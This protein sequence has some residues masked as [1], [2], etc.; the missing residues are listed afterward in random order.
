MQLDTVDLL[1]NCPW[2][3]I[4][5]TKYQLKMILT[6][7]ISEFDCP[8]FGIVDRIFVCN[9]NIILFQCFKLN[10]IMFDEHYQSFEVKKE[11]NE[12]IFVGYNMLASHVPNHICVLSNGNKYVI[13]RG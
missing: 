7:E 8:K 6:L 5:G 13:L 10:T 12:Q 9:N 3:S 2:I 1:I 11:N 4:K